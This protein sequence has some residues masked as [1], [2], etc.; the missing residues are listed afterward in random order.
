[1]DIPGGQIGVF[2]ELGFDGGGDA[3][4]GGGVAEGFAGG[5]GLVANDAA[6]LGQFV[7]DMFAIEVPGA[8]FGGEGVAGILGG[9][10]DFLAR[11]LELRVVFVVVEIPDRGNAQRNA[12]EQRYQK[13]HNK[14]L[15]GKLMGEKY[16]STEAK[17][18][19]GSS[20][21]PTSREIPSTKYQ[22]IAGMLARK[23]KR[24]SGVGFWS[25]A[26]GASLMLGRLGFGAFRTAH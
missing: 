13:S 21:R 14:V 10:F 19:T 23:E 8:Q 16:P 17:A 6:G 24:K 3:T 20:K 2:D 7:G 9:A 25:L 11:I 4:V 18:P 15:G 1:M 26:I 12:D 5:V 22:F